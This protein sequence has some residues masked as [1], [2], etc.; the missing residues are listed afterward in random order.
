MDH[1]ELVEAIYRD[2]RYFSICRKLTKSQERAEDLHSEFIL[3]LLEIKDEKLIKAK[4]GGYL[5]IYLIET[6]NNLWNNRDRIKSYKNGTTSPL[7][8]YSS[9][10]D[11][12]VEYLAEMDDE[13]D[14]ESD[15]QLK[16]AEDRVIEKI[17]QD[18][19]SSDINVMYESRV[20]NYSY[21]VFKN[22]RQFSDKSKIAY[23]T[24]I[25]SNHRYGEKLKKHING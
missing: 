15:I 19:N 18:I 24:I 4:G 5:E 2:K 1:F 25:M 9:T 17:E 3:K 21:R 11:I 16:Q 14:Y 10:S 12:E 13:Y 23:T 8:T 22:P 7:F 20:F 6:I